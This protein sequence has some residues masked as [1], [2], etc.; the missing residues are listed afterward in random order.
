[1]KTYPIEE[2]LLYHQCP[3]MWALEKLGWRP[4]E[5]SGK[6]LAKA[7]KLGILFG[8]NIFN[9]SHMKENLMITTQEDMENMPST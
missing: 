2:T 1:M 4:V 7:I 6:D 3:K 8:F 9:K 5:I